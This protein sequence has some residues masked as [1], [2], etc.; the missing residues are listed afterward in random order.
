MIPAINPKSCL[1]RIARMEY[2]TKVADNFVQRMTEWRAS[3][4]KVPMDDERKFYEW[5]QA[6]AKAIEDSITGE[7]S[8]AARPAQ[9]EEA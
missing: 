4:G 5:R 9:T 8:Y 3:E 6:F 1:P 7:G 2:A